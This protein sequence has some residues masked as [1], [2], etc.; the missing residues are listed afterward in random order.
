MLKTFEQTWRWY[1]PNDPISLTDI[2]QAGATGIVTALHHIPS[3]EVWPIS[4]IEKRKQTIEIKQLKWSV[5]ESVPVH[6]DI[7]LHKDKYKKYI[8]N[9]K[10]T[11]KHLG[12]SG[13]NTVCYNFMPILDWIRTQ[14]NQK[15][16][17]G[18]ETLSFNWIQFIAFDLFILKRNTNDYS[19]YQIK[20]AKNYFHSLTTNQKKELENTVLLRLP[21]LEVKYS[22]SDF[23]QALS[24]YQNITPEV[25]REHLTTF[26]EKIIPVAVENGVRMAIHPDDP[27]FQLFGLPHIVST[28][29][30][31][32]KIMKA[33]D[34]PAN[35]LTFCTGSLGVSKTNDLVK[36]SKKLAGRINFV[37]LRN[38]K[39][40][41]QTFQETYHLDGDL[42]MYNII[43]NLIE[44]Q[45]KSNRKI[46]LRAD[47][48]LRILDDFKKNTYPGYNAIGRLRGLAELRGMATAIECSLHL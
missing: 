44:Y 17:D 33:V 5:V 42:D 28:E 4:E 47:H 25:Y 38:I 31:I 20:Q 14:L 41:D 24:W 16:A 37:H 40:T 10:L 22:L 18:S 19:D 36:L 11:L 8:D 15:N 2:R 35:G 6:E 34:S 39:R 46:P 30:D 43:K 45:S 32:D 29:S 27:P 12:Q 7:K 1:G 21:G 3:G 9:Y 48:G 23:K 26:L 13:I